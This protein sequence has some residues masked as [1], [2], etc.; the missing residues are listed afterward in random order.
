[1]GKLMGPSVAALSVEIEEMASY[2]F[3]YDIF[4]DIITHFLS[5]QISEGSYVVFRPS[6]R[7]DHISF[8]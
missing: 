1:M 8:C 7:C 2:M 6:V 5:K 4:W 3:Y